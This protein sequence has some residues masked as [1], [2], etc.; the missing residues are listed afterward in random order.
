MKM[1]TTFADWPKASELTREQTGRIA[2][3][4]TETDA[5]LERARRYSPEFQDKALI[6]KYE[7]HKAK[8]IRMMT[9]D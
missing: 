9:E 3:A 5:I 2:Q 7:A 8:L 1:Q 6:A 4:I